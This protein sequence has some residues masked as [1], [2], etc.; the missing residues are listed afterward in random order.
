MN[1]DVLQYYAEDIINRSVMTVNIGFMQIVS[2]VVNP[3]IPFGTEF[4]KHEKAAGAG[5]L[6]RL[7]VI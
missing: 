3:L 1:F 6:L 5:K 2:Y 4:D 7:F